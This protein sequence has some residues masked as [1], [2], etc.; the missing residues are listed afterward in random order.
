MPIETVIP[1]VSQKVTLRAP[2]AAWALPVAQGDG[3]TLPGISGSSQKLRKW[4]LVITAAAAT[5]TLASVSIFVWF[6]GAWRKHT[7]IANPTFA[8]G[9]LS[10]IVILSDIIGDNVAIAGTVGGAGNVGAILYPLE[11]EV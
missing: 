8:A 2:V 7:T 10:T 5:V 9:D 1:Q 3:P 11:V 6:D 4:A